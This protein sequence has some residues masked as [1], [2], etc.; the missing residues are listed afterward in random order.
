[1]KI[2]I[3]KQDKIVLLINFVLTLLMLIMNVFWLKELAIY[4]KITFYITIIGM[5][6]IVLLFAIKNKK[7]LMRSSFVINCLLLLIIT[8][9][10]ILNQKNIFRDLS[11]FDK[12]KN[13][14][15]NAGKT[16]Y[17]IFCLIQIIQ[18]VILPVPAFIFYLVGTAIYGP[19]L[20]FLLSYISVIIGSVINFFIGRIFGKKVIGWCVGNQLAEKYRYILGNKGYMPFIIMQI[21]PFFPDDILCMIMGMSSISFLFYFIIILLVKPVYIAIVCYFG[22]GNIIPFSGWGIPVWIL[23]ILLLILLYII[24]TKYQNQIEKYVKNKFTKNK[25]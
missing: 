14:I 5:N 1:M 17:I 9:F 19:T 15:I 23:I 12:V 20:S 11:D 8:T 4:L 3:E 2:T 16:G 25:N 24:F 7:S 10:V 21:L 18:V 13:L 22:N 6:L